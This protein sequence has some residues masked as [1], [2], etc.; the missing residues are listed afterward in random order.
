MVD[1][2]RG[3]HEAICAA[4]AVPAADMTVVFDAGQN[5]GA[6]FA[7]L[8]SGELALHRVGADQRLPG[9]DC[10]ARLRCGRSSAGSG[11]EG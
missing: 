6:N 11:S 9:P 7:H 1:Q 2:L 8:A 5:S 10:V 3:Q 4:A